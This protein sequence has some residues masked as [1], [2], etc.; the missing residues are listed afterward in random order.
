[1]GEINGGSFFLVDNPFKRLSKSVDFEI[2]RPN[3]DS[4][5]LSFSEGKIIVFA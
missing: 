5:G 2:S 1:M 3:L 4:L